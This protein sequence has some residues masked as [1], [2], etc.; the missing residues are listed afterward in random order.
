[1]VEAGNSTVLSTGWKGRVGTTRVVG[2][3]GAAGS[4]RSGAP[5]A[6]RETSIRA[7]GRTSVQMTG[8][9]QAASTR[10]ACAVT[11][12]QV[13]QTRFEGLARTAVSNIVVAP[14]P[15]RT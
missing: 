15:E 2:R 13:V 11:P 10:S 14:F 1:G 8:A 7:R 3:G 6:I 12:A 9:R 4:W 5:G